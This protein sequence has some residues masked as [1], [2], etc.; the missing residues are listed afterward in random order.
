MLDAAGALAPVGATGELYLGGLALARGYLDAPERTAERFVPDPFASSTL[1]A[2]RSTL[3][4]SSDT[5]SEE[6]ERGARR[7]SRLPHR[8]SRAL[9]RRRSARDIGRAD[10]QVKIRGHRVELGEVEVALAQ[11]PEVAACAVLAAADAGGG[12]RLVAYV[13]PTTGRAVAA[14]ELRT[15]CRARLPDYMV[16]SV[17]VPMDALPLTP[18]GK[19]D[20]R[21]LP[22]ADEA[23]PL[24]AADGFAAPRT[25]IE[26]ELVHIWESLLSARPIGIRDDFFALGGH[27][28]LAVRMLHEIERV[29]GRRLPLAALFEH[30]T[31]EAIAYLLGTAVR[32]EGE[33]PVVVLQGEGSAT[34]YVFVHGDIRG[35]GWYCRKL[36][37]MLGADTPLIVLPTIRPGGPH[38]AVT[39]EDMAAVHLAHLR[40]VQPRGPYRLAGY[41]TEGSSRSRWRASSTPRARPSSG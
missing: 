10:G 25:T 9:A 36:A 19:V 28:L 29:R 7:T 4:S 23:E 5:A 21:A 17:F 12:Q 38:A 16:P 1:H 24:G 30:S 11:S 13:V 40:E 6:R 20:R 2:S 27:S 41:C 32:D 35:G 39:I 34:P 8:R 14:A 3:T 22:A 18:S 31:I 37:P 33:P 26:H 15:F